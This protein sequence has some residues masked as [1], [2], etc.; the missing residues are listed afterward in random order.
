M[1][2][3]VIYGIPTPQK[4]TRFAFR[5]GQPH[6]YDP[7]SKDKQHIQWQIK[8]TAPKTPL[9]GPVELTI[10]FFLPIPKATSSKKRNAMLNRVLL[11]NVKPDEDNLAYIV[12]NAL[13]KIVYDDDKQ[14][15][16]K[17]VY[18]LYGAEPRTVIRV[19]PISQL[20]EIGIH[21]SPV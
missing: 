10:V 3:F 11:P 8:A 19:R 13:K 20:E 2:Q 4:Q 1:F 14:V 12:T 16:V 18:K 9:L 6:A 5:G 17:H 21:E 7:S 15:C